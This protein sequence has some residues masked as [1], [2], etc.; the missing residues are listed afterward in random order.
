MY[1]VVY[2]IDLLKIIEEKSINHILSSLILI[3]IILELQIIAIKYFL[4][5]LIIYLII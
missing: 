4:K 2:I 5:A 1:I 3:D